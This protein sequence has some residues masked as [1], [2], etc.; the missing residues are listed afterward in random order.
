MDRGGLKHC[1][2]DICNERP[3]TD[4][5]ER[6]TRARTVNNEKARR[7]SFSKELC[8]VLCNQCHVAYGAN[9]VGV[10]ENILRQNIE[11]YGYERVKEK[12]DAVM[13]ELNDQLY[14]PFPEKE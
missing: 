5:D 9:R 3:G 6:I 11:R 2:C 14:L 1:K 10:T 4:Y 13:S 8:A 12:F 7:L